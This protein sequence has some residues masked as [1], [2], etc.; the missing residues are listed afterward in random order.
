MGSITCSTELSVY[1]YIESDTHI[2]TNIHTLDL[3]SNKYILYI[4]I[5]SISIFQAQIWGC[6]IQIPVDALYFLLIYWRTVHSRPVVCDVYGDVHSVC[7]ILNS[8]IINFCWNGQ[9][10][11]S[12][13]TPE[14]AEL[15][16]RL[17]SFFTE[18]SNALNHR[19]LQ[20][21]F[22][23]VESDALLPLHWKLGTFWVW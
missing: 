6:I 1:L 10:F 23:S 19:F 17:W 9:K 18:M 8:L 5:G 20:W 22:I 12:I 21:P 13:Q 11:S 2:Q 7:I 16:V 15:A 3:S 14:K 4:T